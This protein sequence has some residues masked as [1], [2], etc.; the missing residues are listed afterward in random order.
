ME[1]DP[2]SFVIE[3]LKSDLSIE[4]YAL[5]YGLIEL[6]GIFLAIEAIRK[7]RTSQGAIAWSLSLVTLPFF[8][9][10]FYVAFGRSKFIGMA[11]F[12][13]KSGQE[14]FPF[15]EELHARSLEKNFILE[16]KYLSEED[17]SFHHLA[18]LSWVKGNQTKLLKDGAQTF[19][20][21]F[22]AIDKASSYIL[23]QFYIVR[24]DDL[25]LKLKTKLKE[26]A[27]RGVKVYF[28]PD[29]IG[30][31]QVSEGYWDE[32][33]AS[34]VD[35]HLFHVVERRSRRFQLNFR[36][37][38]KIVIV[39]GLTAFFGGH[40]IGDEYMGIHP[41]LSPW[42]DTHVQVWGPLISSLQ[43]SFLEDW[44]FVRELQSV[45]ELPELNW[46]QSYYSENCTAL[47]VPS[48]PADLLETCGLMFV[49]AI[50]MAKERFWIA[51]PYFI[52][53]GKI[54]SALILA[55]LKGVDVRILLP[56]KPDHR[57]V[58]FARRDFYEKLQN[59]GVKFYHYEDGFLHQKVFLID[60]S[61]AA[62]GTANLDNRSF[63]LNFELTGLF[64]GPE[65][66]GAI[67]RMLEEDFKKSSLLGPYAL[68]N[69]PFWEQVVVKVCRL[70]SPIL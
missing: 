1:A 68:K 18:K 58:Y 33:A 57:M 15:L 6:I 13:R 54:S 27:H 32:L 46:D 31:Y 61:Y 44:Y 62:V 17:L 59:A 24:E 53:D 49:Q 36:N 40:N 29:A 8:A 28:I 7:A 47:L 23:I 37:H 30:C 16:E 56:N 3:A 43:I 48:G 39:D 14:I 64:K 52:P 38:R 2:I 55:A 25:G 5:A 21:I 50:H 10:L 70:F 66:I 65:M 22:D 34:G 41:V 4:F 20:A 11:N 45:G 35:V 42:R 12:R 60:Q 19:E 26:A 9:I 69:R 67:E 63:R 51:S